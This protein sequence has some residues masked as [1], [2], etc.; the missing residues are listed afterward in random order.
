MDCPG[1][2]K[3]GPSL[4]PRKLL[5]EH[6]VCDGCGEVVCDLLACKKCQFVKPDIW[7]LIQELRKVAAGPEDPNPQFHTST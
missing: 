5:P 3:Y 2:R 6:W 4:L 7:P 1:C